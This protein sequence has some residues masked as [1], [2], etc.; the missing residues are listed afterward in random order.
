MGDVF[1]DS[2]A[3]RAD[4]AIGSYRRIIEGEDHE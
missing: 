3:S 2:V 1:Y 4:A